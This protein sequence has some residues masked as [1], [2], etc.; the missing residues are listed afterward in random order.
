MYANIASLNNYRKRLGMNTFVFRPHSGEAG[1][2]EHLNSAFL[3]AHSISHGIL[4]R[5]LP[6]LQYL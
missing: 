5:K 2:P 6:A 4:L 1:D 3:V